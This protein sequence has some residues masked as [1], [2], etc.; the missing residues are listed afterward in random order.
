MITVILP[1]RGEFG[2][3]IMTYVR[4]VH[5]IPG[6]KVVCC[7]P[8]QEP[9][10]PS[11]ARFIYD[12][13]EVPDENRNSAFLK[14]RG[15]REYLQNLRHRLLKE[16][17]EAEIREPLDGLKPQR[18]PQC[19]HSNF[20]PKSAGPEPSVYPEVLVAPRFRKYGMQRNYA[21]W[22]IVMKAVAGIKAQ[23]GGNSTIGIIG[24]KETSIDLPELDDRWKAWG[25]PD[26]L[27]V[28]LHWMQRARL[29]LATD[30][31]LA[32]L[33]VLAGAP[34]KVIYGKAGVI[35]GMENWG[36]ILPHMQ[37][38]AITHCEPILGG[39]DSPEAVI[40]AVWQ[41]LSSNSCR[42]HGAET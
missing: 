21:H 16:F 8:G 28:T 12:W 23:E 9:L 41:Y 19:P 36:W 2:Q 39:W 31:G 10:F 34:L 18:F 33:A 38:H 27:G 1:W 4:W 6:E 14:S 32:H 29:V 20:I 37:A 5:L 3:M 35:P 11:A 25:Y 40:E 15:N 30:S 22:A 26:N 42:Q 7:R 17:P 13:E 24:L